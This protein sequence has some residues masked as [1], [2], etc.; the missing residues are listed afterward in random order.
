MSALDTV[1]DSALIGVDPNNV[2]TPNKWKNHRTNMSQVGI[3]LQFFLTN[4]TGDSILWTP[5]PDETGRWYSENLEGLQMWLSGNIIGS[6][7]DVPLVLPANSRNAEGQEY[8][9]RYKLVDD[10]NNGTVA[11]IRD[12]I[13]RY[14]NTI[15][16]DY[17]DNGVDKN[18]SFYAPGSVVKYLFGL[19]IDQP[20]PE[21]MNGSSLD[22][23]NNTQEFVDFFSRLY[24]IIETFE[25]DPVNG[26]PWKVLAY[27]KIVNRNTP[28][29]YS[30]PENPFLDTL[31]LI[32]GI[33]TPDVLEHDALYPTL[34]TA[35]LE[36]FYNG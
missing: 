2:S 32:K 18:V 33:A 8:W 23:V 12:E 30:Q 21:W 5:A 36:D 14:R 10:D 11:V 35:R 19:D 22:P 6:I 26:D 15:S 3:F 34:V 24:D 27:T 20:M 28:P 16:I 31:M 1:V 9:I 13:D 4:D 17:K 25:S 29:G 7:V